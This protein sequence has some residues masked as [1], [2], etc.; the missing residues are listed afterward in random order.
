LVHI[1]F[2]LRKP[3]ANILT[4][5]KSAMSDLRQMQPRTREPKY[6]AWLRLQGCAC[7]CKSTPPSDASH[8][9]SVSLK[10]KKEITGLG[11][12]PSDMW[13][14]PL[15]HDHHMAQHAFGDEVLW[16]SMHGI[17]P[18]ELALRYYCRYVV[19]CH[20]AANRKPPERPSRKTAR[21]AKTKPKRGVERSEGHKWPSR[22][23]ESR[24]FQK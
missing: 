24:G 14:L 7:G 2:A 4:R 9:R 23:L 17:D 11:T 19:E 3:A 8:L 1:P 18:F 5:R 13:C 21:K 22:K 10:H 20:P 15:R 6:L 16:W 12:K